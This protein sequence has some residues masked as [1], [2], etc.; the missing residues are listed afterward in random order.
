MDNRCMRYRTILFPW[1]D[2]PTNSNHCNAGLF[3][4]K[5]YNIFSKLGS[6]LIM[7]GVVLSSTTRAETPEWTDYNHLLENYVKQG[8]KAGINLTLVDYRGWA[9]DPAWERLLATIRAFPPDRLGNREEIISFY[10]NTYNIFAIKMVLDNRPLD[11]IRDAGSWFRPVWKK[12]AGVLGGREVTLHM[13]EHEILRNLD[14]PR[15][16]MAIVCASLSCPDLATQAYT[17]DRLNE[18]LDSQ[19]KRFLDNEGKG[20]VVRGNRIFISKIF[21]WFEEDFDTYGGVEDFISHYTAVPDDVSIQY[22][23][24]NWSLNTY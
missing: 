4:S 10:I 9:K 20:L 19:S 16:H 23:D 18:D 24:Y 15:I 12:T 11:S 14:E 1:F 2:S 6:K 22:L 5:M 3:S 8:N 13:I 7:A 17:A 21:K